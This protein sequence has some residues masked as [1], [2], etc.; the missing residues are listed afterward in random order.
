MGSSWVYSSGLGEGD[1]LT[2]G[3]P[4]E[5]ARV[6]ALN[7][8]QC[9]RHRTEVQPEGDR[10][11]SPMRALLPPMRPRRATVSFS[12]TLL[13]SVVRR[14]C[15][16]EVAT[17]PATHALPTP[18]DAPCR[19]LRPAWWRSRALTGPWLS[20]SRYLLMTFDAVR[21]APR[22]TPLARAAASPAF[23]LSRIIV[24]SNSANTPSIWNSALPAGVVVS[25]ACWWR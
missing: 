13:V 6:R 20:P 15:A 7:R 24:R 4:S 23:T 2:T 3:D 12:L 25:M 8:C 16:T 1:D 11:R 5:A 10:K 14:S 17:P 9:V 18:P 22:R 19:P 21:G